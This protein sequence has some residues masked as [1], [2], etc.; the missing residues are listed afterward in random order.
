MHKIGA[1]L[2][3]LGQA[4]PRWQALVLAPGY[5]LSNSLLRNEDVFPVSEIT[6]Y[7]M[8]CIRCMHINDMAFWKY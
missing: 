1:C 3:K 5:L 8:Q 2:P 4:D 6:V 7:R